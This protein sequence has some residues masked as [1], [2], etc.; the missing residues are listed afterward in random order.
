M[1][2]M[3]TSTVDVSVLVPV[4]NEGRTIREVVHAMT[5]Q[6]FGGTVEF[7]FADGRSSDDTKAQLEELGRADPRIRVLDNPRRGVASGLNVCLRMARGRYLAR[8][9]GH[10]LYPPTYLQDGVERLARSEVGTEDAVTWVSGP[11]VPMPRGRVATAIAAALATPLGRG[12]SRRWSGAER[13]AGEYELDTGV[14]CGVWRR[15]DVLARGGWD[16][17]WLCNED[18]ELAARFHDAGQRIICLPSMAARYIPRASLPALWRQYRLYG[19]YR[20]K[21]ARRHTRSLRRSAVLPPLLVLDAAASIATRGRV[22]RLARVGQWTYAAVLFAATT[23]AWHAGRDADWTDRSDLGPYAL[24]PVVM[25]IM[26]VAHGMGF[27]EGCVRWGVPWT[28]F[29][30]MVRGSNEL[31]LKPYDGPIEAPSLL[32]E[33]A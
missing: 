9:D 3:A 22:L 30:H 4:L 32:N 6:Q 1:H 19:L 14:F 21:T 18:S 29:W 2:Q 25:T 12:G 33:H 15:D 24:V 13:I 28:A 17:D 20:A 8:M 10:A 5:R 7:L 27:L 23:Q 16:E 31:K 26:H 11:Q